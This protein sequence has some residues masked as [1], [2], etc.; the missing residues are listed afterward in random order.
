M[1]EYRPFGKTELE[2]SAIGYGC[3]EMG[4]TYGDFDS[5]ELTAAVQHAIDL[6]INCFDTAEDYGKGASERF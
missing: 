4:G 2:V 1:M 3:W 5:V 6:G